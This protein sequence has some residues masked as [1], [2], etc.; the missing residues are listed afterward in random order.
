MI[1]LVLLWRATLSSFGIVR[2]AAPAKSPQG[3]DTQ[4]PGEA[5]HQALAFHTN[6][7]RLPEALCTLPLHGVVA[8]TGLMQ[9]RR[10]GQGQSKGLEAAH[11]LYWL[12]LILSCPE[13]PAGS[14]CHQ[15][16]FRDQRIPQ[17]V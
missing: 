14:P 5:G 11:A 3:R 7:H 6:Q 9:R 1:S 8:T 12:L 4:A 10:Q 16:V 15:A 2:E 17:T 13:L